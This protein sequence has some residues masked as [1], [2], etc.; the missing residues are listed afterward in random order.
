MDHTNIKHRRAAEAEEFMQYIEVSNMRHHPTGPT[1]HSHGL[2]RNCG[3]KDTSCECT[4][5]QRKS[6][7]DNV[8]YS[9]DINAVVSVQEDTIADHSPLF[10]KME[11]A[12]FKKKGLKTI[13]RCD[14]S[15]VTCSIFE[16]A[17]ENYNLSPI[18]SMTDVDVAATFIKSIVLGAL[19]KVAPLKPI[20]IRPD[21]APLSLRKDTLKVMAMR[22]T[23]R[24]SN[25]RGMFKNLR[26]KAN[27]LVR[28]D[29][30][31]SVLQRLN[32]NPGPKQTWQEAKSILDKGH[33]AK[34]LPLVTTNTD[35]SDTA[36]TQ[37]TFFAEKISKLVKGINVH[38]E[39]NLSTRP[40]INEKFEFKFATRHSVAKIIKGL[41]NTSSL[42]ID[43]IPT[44]A[45]KLGVE[46]L[47]GPITKLINLSL[48]IGNVPKL[49]KCALVH[50][51]HKGPGKD[52]RDPNSYRPISILSALSKVF[53]IVVRDLM[54]WLEHHEYLPDSQYGF[55]P[56]RSTAMAL[57]CS[58]ADWAEAKLRNEAV[59][60]IAFDLS[61]AF[62][63][64]ALKPLTEKLMAAGIHGLPLKW[65]QNYMTGRSQ[66]VVWNNVT[67][68]P[69]ELQYGV[70]QGSI[71]GPLLFLVMVAD[72]PGYVTQGIY[73]DATVN[74]VCYVN[75]CTL[76][77]SSKSIILLK[78]ILELMS[79]RMIDYCSQAGLVIS[80]GKTQMMCSGI[81]H[82]EFS[83]Q[84]GKSTIYPSKELNL[85]GVA[86]DSN[87][88][89]SPYLKKLAIEA[90]TRATIIK[91]LSYNVPPHLLRTF[92]NGLLVGKI[93]AAAPATVPYRIIHE[94]IPDY[95]E[96]QNKGT[97][98]LTEQINLAVKSAART[99]TRT[100]LIDKIPSKSVLHK[101][102][103][104]SV[105]EMAASASAIM[106]W[107]SRMS[108]NPLR[109]CLFPMQNTN[110]NSVNTR[111][112]KSDKFQM[113]VP[114]YQTLAVNRMATT[115][116]ETPELRNS[117][118]LGSAKSATIKWAK[119]NSI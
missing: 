111:S 103:L 33:E 43:M 48:S 22:D 50:P 107:K 75:D 74:V 116:N 79:K 95:S 12:G 46:I 102:G 49:F 35:P 27:K 40:P 108:R 115:W 119:S 24:K 112:S 14:L 100:R 56:M 117:L 29:K 19:N 31:L 25:N 109:K 30:A 72:L 113:P 51:I 96:N 42:G 104:K 11:I 98:T 53:E 76:Y 63:T 94:C 82:G 37:N 69:L 88:T 114:G 81:K 55:R 87:F 2:Y 60:I 39:K 41:K 16:A 64:V 44:R 36:D 6:A 15:K 67:S 58:Q 91:R 38:E 86:Y 10:I 97:V 32:K 110:L 68:K 84:V 34:Q 99:I 80:E 70:L 89:T 77:A 62:D 105:N 85:L 57:S 73:N 20:K 4:K 7:I 5:T 17:L 101:A 71:L 66:S 61:A 59:A 118:T 3:C 21:K 92:T 93:M 78:K 106:V 65:I 45:W 9:T 28:R 47:A 1:W 52:P 54:E 23:A 8:F 83:T 13:W 26:N 18:C 90:K